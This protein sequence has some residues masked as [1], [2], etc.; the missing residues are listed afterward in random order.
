[1]NCAQA[2]QL[3][4]EGFFKRIGGIPQSIRG[5][6]AYYFIPGRSQR[7]ASLSVNTET[8]EWYDHATGKGG[9]ALDLAITVY[10]TDIS[11]ALTKLDELFGGTAAT[12]DFLFRRQ[13]SSKPKLKTEVISAG[14][15][16]HPAL[17]RYIESR[18]IPIVLANKYLKEIHYRHSG[19]KTFF[20]IGFENDKGG[21]ELSNT[22]FKGCIAPKSITTIAGVT[23]GAI[24]N[25]TEG[26]F[27][28]LS[29]LSYSGKDQPDYDT[30]V[31]NSTALTA[32]AVEII[33][34]YDQVN[35]FLDR[36]K[37]GQQAG[38][39]IQSNQR[40][41]RDYSGIYAGYKDFNELLKARNHARTQV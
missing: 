22:N 30:I 26:F 13:K 40:N 28:F 38:A 19:G 9:N 31:L 39:I 6:E 4:I 21:F 32:K 29:A 41:I 27:D 8:N 3:S 12:N 7:T 15:L 24:I 37:A 2:K 23:S 25:I 16:Q 36:D 17:L 33:K 20:S 1:M 18:C 10:N 35:L 11:G 14:R 5:N 34:K